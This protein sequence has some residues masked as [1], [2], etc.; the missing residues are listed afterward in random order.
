MS[1]YRITSRYAKALL[2]LS[3][4]RNMLD[5]VEKDV[6]LI[7]NTCEA[8]RELVVMLKN[9]IILPQR[10]L[11]VLSDLFKSRISDVTFK[12][13]EVIIRK[14]RS[15]L[16]YEILKMYI[17]EFKTYQHIADAVLYTAVESTE[18]VK[19]SVKSMLATATGETIVL[20]TKVDEKLLGG[21]MIRYKDRLLDAS[22]SSKL[23]ELRKQLL[24]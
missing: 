15:K 2:D 14:N 20:D 3:V 17:E 1:Q 24:D 13:M 19:N 11:A 18:E 22:V 7:V 5:E 6:E 4:E 21:F 8:S 16:V 12:F 10:K 23:R 9:P